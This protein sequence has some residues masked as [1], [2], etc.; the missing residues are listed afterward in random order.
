VHAYG[1]EELFPDVEP[2][3]FF[4][5]RPTQA[6]SYLYDFFPDGRLVWAVSDDSQVLVRDNGED[7]PL[8]SAE[9]LPLPFPRVEVQV[10]REEQVG[11]S[12]P[13]FMNVPEDYQLIQHLLVDETGDLW[14]YI[15]SLG[16][17]GFLHLS[18]RGRETGFYAVEADFDLLSARVIAAGGRMYFLVAGRDE[19]RIHVADL[20]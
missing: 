1:L 6:R 20:P 5:V 14:L 3:G 7:D 4:F 9:W 2:G 8:F 18:D 11:L 12:P 13:F 19:T 15:V 10:M 16:R 17:T